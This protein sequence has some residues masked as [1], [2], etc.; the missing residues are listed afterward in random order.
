MGGGNER[1]GADVI[2]MGVG[3]ENRFE[4]VG[5]LVEEGGGVPPVLARVHAGIEKDGVFARPK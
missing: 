2:V 3:D 5:D 1:K 4:I